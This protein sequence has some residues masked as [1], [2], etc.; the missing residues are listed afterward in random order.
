[1]RRNYIKKNLLL[2]PKYL[3]LQDFVY[4]HMRFLNEHFKIQKSRKCRSAQFD[5]K[6]VIKKLSNRGQTEYNL[7]FQNKICLKEK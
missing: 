2:I 4:N 5:D 3:N 7:T 1:M 6:I